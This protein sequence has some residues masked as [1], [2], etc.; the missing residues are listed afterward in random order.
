MNTCDTV[1]KFLPEYHGGMV[2]SPIE[3]NIKQHLQSCSV[4]RQGLNHLSTAWDLLN[5]IPQ[6]TIPSNINTGFWAGLRKQLVMDREHTTIHNV[7]N[8]RHHR[9]HRFYRFAHRPLLFS[10][11]SQLLKELSLYDGLCRNIYI[12]FFDHQSVSNIP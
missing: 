7:F 8:E 9:H 5:E 2:S 1:R 4:C 10:F 3:K 6:P 12:V 11:H